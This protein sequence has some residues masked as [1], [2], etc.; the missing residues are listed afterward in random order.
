MRMNGPVTQAEYVLSDDEVIITHTD[1]S[2]RI[3]YANPAF[4]KASQ[5]ALDECLGEP[6]NIVR[7]PDMPREV[8]ADMWATIQAGKSWT[9]IVKNRR[10]D[11]GFYWVR[12]NITPITQGDRKLGYMSVRVKPTRQ[13]IELAE[14][15]YADIRA[16]RI[17]KVRVKEGRIIDLT[18]LGTMQRLLTHLPLQ[19]GTWL[20][21]GSLIAI[22]SAILVIGLTG[23]G[24]KLLPALAVLGIF[25]SCANLYYVQRYVVKPIKGL[26]VAASRLLTGDTRTRITSDAVQC[27]DSLAQLFEQLRVKLHGVLRDNLEAAAAV[28]G[29]VAEVVNAS[30]IITNRTHEHAASLEQT[31]ASVE[32]ITAT[33]TRNTDGAQ[34]AAKLAADSFDITARGRQIVSEVHAT[35]GS[36]LESSRQ[37]G[38]IVGII[39]GIAFQTNLLAL[40]AAVEA[41]RAGDQGRGFA[42]V[43]QEVRNLA[44]RSAA[45][46]KEIKDL[47]GASSETVARGGELASEAENS[48][49]QVVEAVK[50]VA[51]V[52]QDI[53]NASREQAA[54]VQ[55]ISQAV[56]HMDSIAQRDASA[57]EELLRTA[58]NLKEQSEHMF[59]A[60]SA[61][62][63]HSGHAP[64]PVVAAASRSLDPAVEDEREAA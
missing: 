24:L 51:D 2:G 25:L 34:Q 64:R 55:Q 14:R 39:D 42:V 8:F 61:F 58:T 30:G 62:A 6:Q 3:T 37:I 22:L 46:A 44:Q 52:I 13:E 35:M 33:V 11:G 50:R 4:V 63:L 5:L 1:P 23:A 45:S 56:M 27:V 38:E 10:K 26:Q 28:R 59:S 49:R 54:G 18:L 19:R 7:H 12:A 17:G 36:I 16:G 41:A 31:A 48:M 20:V 9:G 32:Q 40:N 15:V 53:Q 47:I 21:L 57:A 29:H 43:A 60:I